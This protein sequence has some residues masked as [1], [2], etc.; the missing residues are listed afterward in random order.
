MRRQR[1]PDEMYLSTNHVVQTS[2]TGSIDPFVFNITAE[3]TPQILNSRLAVLY[4]LSPGTCFTMTKQ[5]EDGN[6]MTMQEESIH[7]AKVSEF[8]EETFGEYSL[9]F[10]KSELDVD[11]RYDELRDSNFA[12][13]PS[14]TA[15]DFYKTLSGTNDF[16]NY[17]FALYAQRFLYRA[18]IDVIEGRSSRLM[19]S[20]FE[21]IGVTSTINEGLLA[22]ALIDVISDLFGESALWDH[23]TMI[24]NKNIYRGFMAMLASL[25]FHHKIS[26]ALIRAVLEPFQPSSI[27][28]TISIGIVLKLRSRFTDLDLSKF[29]TSIIPDTFL[30]NCFGNVEELS[31]V[32][33]NCDLVPI[34]PFVSIYCRIHSVMKHQLAPS[35]AAGIVSSIGSESTICCKR[36]ARAVIDPV[37][38]AIYDQVFAD[39]V[40]YLEMTQTQLDQVLEL[41]K[42]AEPVWRV[43]LSKN[44]GVQATALKRL[45]KLL[46]RRGFEPKGLC[47]AIF[48][49]M[50]DRNIILGS[51]YHEYVRANENEPGCSSV[52]L[53][54][55]SLLLSRI[56]QSVPDVVQEP[57]APVAG[58]MP[59][60]M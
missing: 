22:N 51:S 44:R 45:Q 27:T 24:A 52:I 10:S 2:L 49:F 43:T 11:K 42:R 32:L 13:P 37:F 19:K 50:Y 9:S 12:I 3:M 31:E 39:G 14:L 28:K 56:P 23:A 59:Q 17:L 57:M 29:I 8:P 48:G 36:I 7:L 35:H 33:L 58:K 15:E 54:I 25:I 4:D 5:P 21:Y 30:L 26:G 20:V 1:Q 6:D 55:N 60:K 34:F 40:P 53:E 38:E 41:L 46:A 47:F 16:D 18:I